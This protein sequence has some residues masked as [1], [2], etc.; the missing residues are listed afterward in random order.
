MAESI[1]LWAVR[2]GG[3]LRVNPAS[4]D[5]ERRLEDWIE[6]HPDVLGERLLPIGRQIRTE[7][8]GIVD[9]LALDSEGR[10]VVIEL[11][12]GK[13]PRDIVGQALD[14]ISWVHKLSDAD[15]RNL[16]AK[17]IGRPFPEIYR[18]RFEARNPP[19]ELNSDQRMMIVCTDADEATR[20]ILDY[21]TERHRMDVNVITLS[22]YQVGDQELIARTWVVDPAELEERIGVEVTDT[23]RVW[24]GLWH[25]NLGAHE[26]RSW[27]D[28]RRYGFVSAG[29]G[30]KWRDEISKLPVGAHLY[31]YINGA[32]YCGGGTVTSTAVRADRFKLNGEAGSLRGLPLESEVWLRHADDDEIAEYVVGVDW[33]KAVPET[34]GLRVPYPLRGTVRK[35]YSPELALSL[36]TTFG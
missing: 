7:F 20:R 16:I 12:R 33:K 36:R 25:F 6:S 9:L 11:K 29:G 10:G 8:G 1:G 17:N 4:I 27:E 31:T 26:G 3:L 24:T 34:D 15:I 5:R 14:Y 35:I 28:A 21:L 13:T 19:T 32:G 2:D 23:E 18:E 30:A 22:Y